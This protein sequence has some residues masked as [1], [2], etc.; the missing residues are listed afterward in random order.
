MSGKHEVSG[1]E[2]DGGGAPAPRVQNKQ[3]PGLRWPIAHG[4]GHTPGIFP[5]GRHVH[6]WCSRQ[7]GVGG[8]VRGRGARRAAPRTGV[9]RQAHTARRRNAGEERGTR[10]GLCRPARPPKAPESDA[11]AVAQKSRGSEPRRCSEKRTPDE[12]SRFR[13]RSGGRSGVKTAQGLV[14]GRSRPPPPR[15]PQR[16]DATRAL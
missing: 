12:G 1:K 2:G 15:P 8:G 5:R 10:A 16:A 7:Q 14:A 11:K 9:S 3:P 13:V 6:A 4:S